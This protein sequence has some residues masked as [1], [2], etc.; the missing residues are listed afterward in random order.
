MEALVVVGADVAAGEDLF[1]VPEEGG[2]HG[3][4]VFE[5][6]VLGAVLHH[7]DL[8]VALD[9]LGLD[10]AGLLVHEDLDRQLAVDDLLADFGDALGTERV[11]GARPAERRLGLLIRLQQRLVRPLGRE[12]W[13]GINAIELVENHPRAFGGDG[14]SFFNILNGLV[15]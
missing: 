1:Q 10:L 12:R 5:V 8:A 2:V 14:D 4:D 9:D 13:V 11:G 7:E 6:A 15:H 3:H